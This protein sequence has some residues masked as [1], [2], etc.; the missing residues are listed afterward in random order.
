MSWEG[1]WQ[2]ALWVFHANITNDGSNSGN[3]VYAV[4]QSPGSEMEILYGKLANDDTSNRTGSINLDDGTNFLAALLE[5]QAGLTINAGFDASFPHVDQPAATGASASPSR[6]LL[7]GGM[8][9]VATLFSVAVVQDSAFGVVAR[10]R[11]PPLPTVTLT[12]P[13]DATEVV[14]TNLVF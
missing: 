13:T 4:S 3:H 9:L 2:G 5:D 11:Y 10:I 8:R 1:I 6:I 12:S 7:A 14:D